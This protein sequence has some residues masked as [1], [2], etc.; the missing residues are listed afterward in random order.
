[1]STVKKHGIPAIG[2]FISLDSWL[3][4]RKISYRD[5]Y[6]EPAYKEGKL[7][8]QAAQEAAYKSEYATKTLE[9][10]LDVCFDQARK[11]LIQQK[12]ILKRYF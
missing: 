12:Q 6:L 8:E 9:N 2:G 3:Q 1:M 7:K 10:N 5:S 11:Q 4:S